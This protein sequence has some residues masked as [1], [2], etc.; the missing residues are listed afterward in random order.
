MPSE[1]DTEI[2]W[3]TLTQDIPALQAYC[4][5]ILQGGRYA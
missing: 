3:E 5:E 1:R 2:L 4:Q